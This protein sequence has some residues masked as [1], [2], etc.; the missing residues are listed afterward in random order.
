[1]PA[2]QIRWNLYLPARV[3]AR[4]DSYCLRRFG[5]SRGMRQV[6]IRDAVC[7][8][9]DSVEKLESEGEPITKSSLQTQMEDLNARH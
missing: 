6:F 7:L 9:I 2:D 8:A 4:I 5:E 1:M 3:A